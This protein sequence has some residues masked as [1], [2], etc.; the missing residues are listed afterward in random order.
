[1][2]EALAL[3]FFKVRFTKRKCLGWFIQKKL[4]MVGRQ[5]VLHTI[6]PGAHVHQS[7]TSLLLLLI[8][9]TCSRLECTALSPAPA[10]SAQSFTFSVFYIS[11]SSFPSLNFTHLLPSRCLSCF[12][13]SS[14]SV[15]P[16]SYSHLKSLFFTLCFL[17]SLCF[18]SSSFS[19]LQSATTCWLAQSKTP[20]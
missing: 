14:S 5:K 19:L 11:P 3:P 7:S 17:L 13:C 8:L 6:L 15:P 18:H 16:H 9:N 10:S 2:G 4:L 12:A 20:Y 1:M